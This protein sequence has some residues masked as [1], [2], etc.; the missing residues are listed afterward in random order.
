VAGIDAR[1]PAD[2]AAIDADQVTLPLAIRARR[3]GDRF[4]PLG[5][6]GR[7][8]LQDILVDRKVPR[9]SRDTT[10]IV[11]D[12]RDRIVWV[13]GHVVA[14]DARVT[15]ATTRMLLLTLRPAGGAV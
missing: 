7:R 3:P 10:P 11:V 8:K 15:A 1:R 14:H 4:R 9:A 13:A 12:A 6:D 5:G 2:E